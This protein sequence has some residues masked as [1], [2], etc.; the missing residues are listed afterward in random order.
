MHRAHLPPISIEFFSDQ[1]R[2]AG[3]R[4]LAEFDMLGEDRHRV[5]V[6]D[7]HEGVEHR[8]RIIAAG[9]TPVTAAR[10]GI[11]GV[12]ANPITRPL[13]ARNARRVVEICWRVMAQPSIAAAALWI[14]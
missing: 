8:K 1:R 11:L 13:P 3:K 4:P 10:A 9:L 12:S 14:A 5:V 6:A 2:K 7:L